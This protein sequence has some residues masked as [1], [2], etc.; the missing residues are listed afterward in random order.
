MINE[1][2]IRRCASF[3]A[4]RR[5]SCTDHRISVSVIVAIFFRR[6]GVGLISDSRHDRIGKHDE[7]DVPV[8]AMPGAAFVMVET[9]FVLGGLETFLDTPARAGTCQRL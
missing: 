6:Y 2:G 5:I 8:P 7:R 4:R 3:S 1:A 9:E